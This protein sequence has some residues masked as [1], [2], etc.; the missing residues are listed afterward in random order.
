MPDFAYRELPRCGHGGVFLCFSHLCELAGNL[1]DFV[2]ICFTHGH[3][4]LWDK[5]LATWVCLKIENTD[6]LPFFQREHADN[7]LELGVLYFQTN[8]DGSIQAAACSARP[9]HV[10][11][12][13]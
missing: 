2:E 4:R 9:C 1:Y 10:S 5:V 6:K 7:P 3:V 8:P 11:G 13:S 12:P